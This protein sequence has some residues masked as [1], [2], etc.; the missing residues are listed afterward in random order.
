MIR[1]FLLSSLA[2]LA[3]AGEAPPPPNG[4]DRPLV[5][6]AILLDD[7]GSMQGLIAQARSHLWDMVNQLVATRYQGKAPK[8]QVALYHYGNT[9][10]L[11]QP[12]VPLSDDLDEVS[13]QL[14]AINGGGG[15]ELCGQVIH[16]AVT[17]LAWS[18]R[19]EDLKLIFIAGNE[20]FTQGPLDFR[21]ACKEAIEKGIQV[22]T[23]HCGSE[24]EG[25]SGKWDEGARL[26]DGSFI[27]I[28]HNRA[29]PAIE[30]PQDAEL[31]ALNDRLNATYLGYGARGVEK[32]R[33]Q[34]AQDANALAASPSVVSARVASKASGG[35]QNAS[36]DL[37][38]AVKAGKK[39]SDLKEDEL[40]AELRPL[41]P[42]QREAK[43]AE[44]AQQRSELQQQIAALSAARAT[45][46][47]AEEAK[48][49]AASGQTTLGQ[50]MRQAIQEQAAKKGYE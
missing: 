8:L 16:N 11:A 43:V 49:A 3:L 12:L 4:E 26:A 25:R 41:T 18:P 38:D 47:A 5:Q 45:F 20:P 2:A 30:A 28:D 17:Q 14:F 29:A 10:F 27:C 9:P 22:N 44:L 50:A 46:V 6:V 1:T 32:A 13:K 42:E 21:V 48:Q 40:P 19:R 33:E 24:S 15:D 36:W 23:I 34:V 7:S 39:V 35:Y 31:A 37:V